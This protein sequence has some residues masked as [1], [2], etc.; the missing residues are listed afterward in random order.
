[1]C[2]FEDQSYN[3]NRNSQGCF[4]PYD[5]LKKIRSDSSFCYTSKHS[6]GFGQESQNCIHY[7]E[8]REVNTKIMYVKEFLYQEEEPVTHKGHIRVTQSLS[9]NKK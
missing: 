1:M 6:L 5:F 8:V 9:K 2:I 7:V 3:K 4:F